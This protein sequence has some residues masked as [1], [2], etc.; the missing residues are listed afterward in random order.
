MN[1]SRLSFDKLYWKASKSG[2]GTNFQSFLIGYL[3]AKYKKQPFFINDTTSNISESYHLIQDTFKNQPNVKFTQKKGISIF[4]DKI[5][6]I[7]TYLISLD[8]SIICEEAK[9]VFTLNS[10]LEEK[11]NILKQDIPQ[12]D[13]GI[14]IRMGDKITTGEMKVIELQKYIDAMYEY[15]SILQ[16]DAINVYIMTDNPNI[17]DAIKQKIDP[18]ISIF[19]LQS[20]HLFSGGHNQREYNMLNS[21]IKYSLFVHFMTELT[22]LQAASSILCTFSS[23]IGRFLYMT[24]KNPHMVKSLDIPHFT[25]LHDMDIF[26]KNSTNHQAH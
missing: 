6:E 13:I 15:K 16:K 2:Y 4:D 10:G 24:C 26:L 7:N 17:I 9:R 20:E 11:I 5:H 1:S 25:I 23:N 21:N 18:T 8:T 22:I 19:N 12:I 14:H 3:F